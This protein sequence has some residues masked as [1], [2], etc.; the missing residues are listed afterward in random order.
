MTSYVG[1]FIPNISVVH[2]VWNDTGTSDVHGNATATYGPPI[3]RKAIA[4]YP[5]HKLPH[6][7]VVS[8]EYIARVMVDFIMEVP[9]A[10]VYHKNDQVTWD[11]VMFLV[12][13]FPFNWGDANPFGFDRTMFGGSVHITR[14]G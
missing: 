2:E 9:D 6:H 3:T 11:G 4:V 1:A 5:L 8:A 14:V 13:G 12:E 10:T 7:D